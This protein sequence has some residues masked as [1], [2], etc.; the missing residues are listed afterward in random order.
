MS[1]RLR[2]EYEQRR[3]YPNS[4][5]SPRATFHNFLAFFNL[6]ISDCYPT[7][8]CVEIEK[9]CLSNAMPLR[10]FGQYGT[11]CWDL[12]WSWFGVCGACGG[13]RD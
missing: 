3:T 13:N 9:L 11:H 12:S 10:A 4:F 7:C 6:G 1:E 5:T 2:P 8:T